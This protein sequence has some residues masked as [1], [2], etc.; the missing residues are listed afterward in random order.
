MLNLE[1]K[2][3]VIAKYAKSGNDTGSSEVQIALWSERIAQI[4]AHLKKF[5]KDNHS[6]H[7]LVKLVGKRQRAYDYLEKTDTKSL[8][9]MKQ[10]MKVTKS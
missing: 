1:T 6:R 10:A 3:A 7:G 2:K 5:P 8:A 9:R 4:A